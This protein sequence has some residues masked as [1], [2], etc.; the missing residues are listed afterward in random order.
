[1]VKSINFDKVSDIYD[2]YVNV[3]FDIPFYLN[4]TKNCDSE[5]LE[6]MCGTGRVS[7]PLLESGKKM[8]CI[9]YSKGMLET[10]SKKIDRFKDK[11]KL[12]EMDV[13]QL[14]LKRKYKMIIL[15]FHS[16]S[17]ITSSEKQ[18]DALECISK[19]LEEN[20]TFILTLQNPNKRLK[21]ADGSLRILGEFPIDNSRKAILS[22]MNQYDEKEKVVNGYQFYEIY[23]NSN[24]L[25]EKR[26]LK[27]Q[28]KPLSDKELKSMIER[29]NLKIVET[30]GDYS[31]S[32]FNDQT[33]DFIIYKITNN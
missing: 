19:H 23:N 32:E 5:I 9:D 4:E 31:Y 22:S 1:M 12:I 3:D 20:G 6:L 33:S 26:C 11:V 21:Q 13:T 30:Y 25:I 15:P 8:T 17:E 16:I 14:D 2:Y 18:F 7:I 29:L 24:V 10:F 28:F 27:I